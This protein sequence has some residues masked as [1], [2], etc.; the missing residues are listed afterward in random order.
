MHAEIDVVYACMHAFEFENLL[1]QG[2]LKIIN[3]MHVYIELQAYTRMTRVLR[4]I[5]WRRLFGVLFHI[6]SMQ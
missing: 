5:Q 2:L 1:H 4:S 6:V 3:C